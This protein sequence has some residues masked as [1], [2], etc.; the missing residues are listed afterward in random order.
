LVASRPPRLIV[1]S[2]QNK[3]HAVN[4]AAQLGNIG[5]RCLLFKRLNA[6][7]VLYVRLA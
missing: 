1:G 6:V 4:V 3:R 2:A 7:F 5:R